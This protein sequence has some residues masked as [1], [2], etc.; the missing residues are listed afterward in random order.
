[1]EEQEEDEG[2]GME[3]EQMSPYTDQ[4]E[5]PP[6]APPGAT[7]TLSTVGKP[8]I[9]KNWKS[10]TNIVICGKTTGYARIESA[11]EEQF[12]IIITA[13]LSPNSRQFE[14]SNGQDHMI[15]EAEKPIPIYLHS[16]FFTSMQE[17]CNAKKVISAFY[18]GSKI[19]PEFTL[20]IR[21]IQI[22]SKIRSVQLNAEQLHYVDQILKWHPII[23]G[24]GPFGS[25][26]SMTMAMAAVLAARKVPSRC[27]LLVTHRTE[28]LYKLEKWMEQTVTTQ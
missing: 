14:F 8:E 6:A 1:M 11:K 3:R 23:I 28:L 9:P 20:N 24:S 7:P 15:F 13:R 21:G 22:M 19:P 5:S 16:R 25:G 18:G 12:K 27:H 2:A 4:G 26:K 10:G 17:D